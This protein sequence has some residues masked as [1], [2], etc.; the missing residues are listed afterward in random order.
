VRVWRRGQLLARVILSVGG[1]QMTCSILAG[2]WGSELLLPVFGLL[3]LLRRRRRRGIV[4]RVVACPRCPR[5]MVCVGRRPSGRRRRQGL[6]RVAGR[7]ALLV[8]MLLLML[9]LGDVV[10]RGARGRVC[11][12]LLVKRLIL[13]VVR[14]S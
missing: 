1:H 14:W 9:L 5:D 6:V 2:R 12:L 4:L 7:V 8:L 13:R 11:G 10:G 3:L